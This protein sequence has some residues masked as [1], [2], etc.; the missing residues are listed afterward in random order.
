MPPTPVAADAP[1]AVIAPEPAAAEP[2]APVPPEE[3]A[4]W[5]VL[6]ALAR[7]PG[8]AEELGW[9]VDAQARLLA[10][11]DA[12]DPGDL[13]V[14]RCDARALRCTVSQPGGDT[15]FRFARR[16]KGKAARIVLR[17]VESEEP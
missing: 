2:D 3:R 11:D 12:L 1:A 5:E 6:Q 7:E 17:A 15:R 4:L 13:T 8:R 9:L 16:G 10:H 14:A